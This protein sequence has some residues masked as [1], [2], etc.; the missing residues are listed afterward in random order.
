MDVDFTRS[1]CTLA[2]TWRTTDTSGKAP[3]RYEWSVGEQGQSMG[4]GLLDVLKEPLWREIGQR[5]MAIYTTGSSKNPGKL[6]M[7][8]GV[9]E[10]A[11]VRA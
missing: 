4:G 1:Q 10:C 7:C 2:A 8:V 5:N 6:R 9:C 3:E 11:F